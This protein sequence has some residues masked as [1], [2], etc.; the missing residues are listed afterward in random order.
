MRRSRGDVADVDAVDEHHPRVL[1][2]PEA[3][4]AGVELEDVP[5]L[6]AEDLVVVDPDGLGERRVQADALVVTVEGHHVARSR[7]VQHQLD[8]L[9]IAVSGGVDRRVLGRDHLTANVVET[10]D[11][12][13]DGALVAGHRRRRENDRVTLVELDLRVVAVRHPSQRRERLP[14]RAG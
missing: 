4:A 10:V 7:E 8:L 3:G 2:G 11:R 12:L 14:L 5:V 13:V 1:R 6:G 9:R